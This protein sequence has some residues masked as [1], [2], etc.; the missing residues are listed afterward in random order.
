LQMDRP[1]SI[2]WMERVDTRFGQTDLLFIRHSAAGIKEF[3]PDAI[4]PSWEIMIF[5]TQIPEQVGW[6]SSRG[7]CVRRRTAFY[8]R[9]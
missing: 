8:L 2:T 3:C 4:A 5:W 7:A 6:T 1:F 9:S